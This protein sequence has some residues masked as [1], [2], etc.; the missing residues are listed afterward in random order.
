MLHLTATPIRYSI[1]QFETLRKSAL[2][3]SVVYSYPF[4]QDMAN[5]FVTVAEGLPGQSPGLTI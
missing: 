5:Y 2:C 4:Q 3:E 1:L